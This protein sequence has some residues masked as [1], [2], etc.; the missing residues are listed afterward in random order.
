MNLLDSLK[1][2]LGIQ[3]VNIGELNRRAVHEPLPK[4]PQPLRADPLEGIEITEE[5]KVVAKLLDAGAPIVFVSGKAGTGKSTLIHYIRHVTKKNTVVVA[6]TGIAALNALGVTI[7]S[8][9]RLPPRVIVPEDVEEVRDRSLYSKLDLLIV[10]EVSMVRADV[11]DGMDRF[12]RMN[13]KLKSEPFGGTQLLLVGD[14][15]QLPPVVTQSEEAALLSSHY[16]SPYFFS[17]KALQQS[18]ML[19]VELG[20]IFRQ[21]DPAFT[22]LLNRIRVAEDLGMVI[23]T[24]NSAC[25]TPGDA[26]EQILTLTCTNADADRE[27]ADRLS[28]LPGEARTFLGEI[29][30]KFQVEKERLPSPVN[31]ELKPGAQV[32]FTKNDGG[33]RWVNG[34]LGRVKAL[35]ERTI[36]VEM[37]SHPRGVVHEVE[38]AKWESYRYRFDKAQDRI[39]PEVAGVYTQF[40][41]MLAWAVTI[42]KSQGKTLERVRV[43]LGKGAFSPGQVYVALS[44]CRSLDDIR[45]ARPI[46]AKDVKCD[47][48]IKRFFTGIADLPGT[49]ELRSEVH[50]PEPSHVMKTTTARGG[51][52][53]VCPSCGG[54]LQARN[55]KYGAFLGCRNYP[56]CKYTRNS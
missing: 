37:V 11:M 2:M 16:D 25:S 14:L 55:G 31:L 23:P 53:Q 26:A 12:L 22:D 10:D 24:I 47:P 32:M 13:G 43:D 4:P 54:E 6:P 18:Q 15:F 56:R 38:R 28:S 21:R 45:L 7:H 40:P 49:V 42:H 34:S 51:E 46:Q 35:L 17:A 9:F 30:G 1:T 3:P 33:K 50:R 19:P 36:Q 5:Y 8:Y 48:I 27:N 52:S 29:T 44:R 39:L 41:L 20:K